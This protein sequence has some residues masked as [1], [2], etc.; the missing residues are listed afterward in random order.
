FDLIKPSNPYVI[1]LKDLKRCKQNAPP[2]FDMFFNLS[3]FIAYEHYQQQLDEMNEIDAY[4]NIEYN[5]M[6]H[7]EQERRRSHERL[8]ALSA[9]NKNISHNVTLNNFKSNVTGNEVINDSNKQIIFEEDYDS[10][11]K[12]SE[13][14]DI[15]DC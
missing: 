3:K 2:F 12:N 7:A 9:I 5:K 14:D 11:D 6:L 15:E 4:V 10:D 13:D 1:T 8:E